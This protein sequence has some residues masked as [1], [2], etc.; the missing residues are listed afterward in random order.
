MFRRS[1]VVNANEQWDSALHN[2]NK[3][4]MAILGGMV[5]TEIPQDKL[6]S[7]DSELLQ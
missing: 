3:S 1:S 7:T 4:S 5:T 6:V 2:T